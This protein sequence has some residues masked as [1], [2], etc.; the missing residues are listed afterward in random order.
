MGNSNMKKFKNRK[1]RYSKII[2]YVFAIGYYIVYA[3]SI[4]LY[5]YIKRGFAHNSLYH[6]FIVFL[7]E[8]YEHNKAVEIKYRIND[9]SLWACEHTALLAIML[10]IPMFTDIA[11]DIKKREKHIIKWISFAV[12]IGLIIFVIY[13]VAPEF[14][15]YQ[16]V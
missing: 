3:H 7:Y 11:F 5:I 12:I 1:K 9:L 8:H 13:F 4:S 14:V 16:P 2:T 6:R 15:A 10:L